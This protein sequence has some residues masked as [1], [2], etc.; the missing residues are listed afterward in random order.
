MELGCHYLNTVVDEPKFSNSNFWV[1]DAVSDFLD[2]I[3]NKD[4]IVKICKAVTPDF[5]GKATMRGI[6]LIDQK[7]HNL[8]EWSTTMSTL[9]NSHP[10][11]NRFSWEKYIT[12]FEVECLSVKHL[13]ATY[14]IPDDIDFLSIDL[15][16]LDYDIIISLIENRI[17]PDVIRFESKLM[18]KTQL[19]HIKEYLISKNYC[20]PVP[21]TQLDFNN[22]PYNH[23]AWISDKPNLDMT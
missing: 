23:W 10:T 6:S 18:N 9:K 13:W 16:G 21:G 2:F 15:E 3:P 20:A 17:M 11:I 7:A 14:N 19:E 12:E 1:V 4:N 8:P 22:A 5:N